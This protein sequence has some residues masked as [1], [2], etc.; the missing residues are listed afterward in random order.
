MALMCCHSAQHD[1]GVG[2]HVGVLNLGGVLLPQGVP[3][4]VIAQVRVDG[5]VPLAGLVNS[6]PVAPLNIDPVQ[7]DERCAGPLP[8]LHPGQVPRG[9]VQ[10]DQSPLVTSV[11]DAE[12]SSQQPAR[13]PGVLGPAF[14][15]AETSGWYFS[16]HGEACLV[17]SSLSSHA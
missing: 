17:C 11:C 15:R 8:D 12:P 10:L 2:P 16:Y 1:P 6:E 14:V 9:A 5:Q 13:A 4:A 7:V 3:P